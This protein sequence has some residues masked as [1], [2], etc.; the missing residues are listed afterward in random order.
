MVVVFHITG[1]A[2]P[3]DP[4]LFHV[5]ERLWLGVPVFFVISGYCVSA[6]ADRMTSLGE[7]ARRRVRRIFPPYLSFLA[8]TAVV[9]AFV[10]LFPET[11]FRGLETVRHG[12]SLNP[13]QWLGNLTLTEGWRHH[14][15]DGKLNWFLG[16]AWTL[17]YEEQ[18]YAVTGLV[19]WVSG[20]H[21]PLVTAFITVAVLIGL[22]SGVTDY[23]G[24]WFDGRWLEFAFGAGAYWHLTRA[25]GWL[26]DLMPAC[27]AAALLWAIS[28]PEIVEPSHSLPLEVAA[29]SA[30]AS[31]MIAMHRL[32]ARLV[33]RV[34]WL[35]WCGVRSYSV[36]LV[37]WPLTQ[38]VI[39]VALTANLVSPAAIL[40]VLVPCA[41]AGSL[42]LGQVLH[43]SI[44]RRF[45]SS[46]RT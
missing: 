38:L 6:A 39:G 5:T 44:E 24:F 1:W 13:W 15:V 4:W 8:V 30:C 10:G 35:R 17:G 12:D 29:A 11:R 46:R 14:L 40:L 43:V 33:N 28:Q 32:D 2:Q 36:Y 16:H 21:W 27:A 3:G 23:D 37:H 41:I 20:R 22:T 26:R 42:A 9:V 45:M 25:R 31:V 19:F 18:F 7:Y 34:R